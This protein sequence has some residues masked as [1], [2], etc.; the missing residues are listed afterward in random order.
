M[1]FEFIPTSRLL[2]HRVVTSIQSQNEGRA[3]LPPEVELVLVR[4]A[5]STRSR[6]G[7][8][9]RLYDAPLAEG[10]EQQLSR[11]RLELGLLSVDRLLSS[12]LLRC[13]QTTE[14]LFPGQSFELVSEF[15]AFHSGSYETVTE[16]FIRQT[17][18]EY[19][20]LSYRD[21]FLRPRF[22]E[23][24][25]ELQVVRVARGLHRILMQRDPSLV[26]V[27]HYSSL[28]IIANLG[29]RQWDLEAHADGAY[30]VALGGYLRLAIDP[31]R[32]SQDIEEFLGNL[33]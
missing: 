14:F 26:I 15:R 27:T 28:N 30:D 25:I 4:H 31:R 33:L 10:F 2:G 24:S 17:H 12:P 16:E 20:G 18:P 19:L 1:D 22:N 32:V 7:V 5:A 13:T 21:R 8:W 6:D 29:V 3:R 23:E 11:T 9:G